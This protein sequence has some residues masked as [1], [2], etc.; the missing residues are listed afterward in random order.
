[1]PP[2]AASLAVSI[3][4]GISPAGLLAVPCHQM[5]RGPP[6]P[7]VEGLPPQTFALMELP[8]ALTVTLLPMP[9]VNVGHVP[10]TIGIAGVPPA[11]TEP[12]L[13][14][15]PLLPVPLLVPLLPPVL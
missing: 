3:E 5:M 6:D 1:M 12:E 4:I 14:F 7:D 9:A 8:P 15:E 11:A 10:F 2:S 13:E